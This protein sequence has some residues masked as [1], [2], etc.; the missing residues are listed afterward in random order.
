MWFKNDGWP[1]TTNFLSGYAYDFHD[2]TNCS[3]QANINNAFQIKQWVDDILNE[4]GA[5]KVDLIGHSMGGWSGRYYIKFLDGI[6]QVDDYV[7]FGTP[8]T[9]D[10]SYDPWSGSNCNEF[11]P[12]LISLN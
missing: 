8:H 2:T 5:E 7:S 6:D 4:T 9:S 12:F 10:T 11:I 3:A 1:N